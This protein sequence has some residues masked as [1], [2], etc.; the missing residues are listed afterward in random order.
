MVCCGIELIFSK[1]D[2]VLVDPGAKC[3]GSKVDYLHSTTDCQKVEA[4]YRISDLLFG[5]PE[6]E[7]RKGKAS[8]RRSS[9]IIS[10]GLMVFSILS[11]LGILLDYSRIVF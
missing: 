11:F 5:K 3:G 2:V 6:V 4:I 10:N 7:C 9:P 8:C 1:S